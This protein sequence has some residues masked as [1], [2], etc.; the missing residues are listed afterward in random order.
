M[1][2]V[3]WVHAGVDAD[4]DEAFAHYLEVDPALAT[5]FGME[6]DAALGFI[7]SFPELGRFLFEDYRRVVLRRFPYLIVY[8]VSG[9]DV[10]VLRISHARREP[11]AIQG[12]ITGRR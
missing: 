10:R 9:E 7:E 2:W 11:A 5:R 3:L 1:N 6:V 12:E 8:C 4:L